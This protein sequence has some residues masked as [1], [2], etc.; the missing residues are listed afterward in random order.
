[1]L[2]ELG[3]VDKGVQAIFLGGLH[4]A[5]E[6][7]A[8]LGSPGRVREEP[9][10]SA[11]DKWLDRTFRPVVVDL[12]AAVEQIALQLVPL[13]QAIGHRFA[14]GAFRQHDR[15]LLRQPGM[16][17]VQHRHAA[18]EA[19]RLAF[20]RREILQL[21]FDLKEAVAIRQTCVR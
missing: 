12:Q 14:K 18:G 11:D 16:K 7:R 13:V 17:L 4:V 21:P 20:V 19:L 6:D 3:D 8:G 10:L 1:M 9:V 15:G 2:K 5:V